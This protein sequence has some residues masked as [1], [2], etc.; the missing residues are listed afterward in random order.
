MTQTIVITSG[1]G[2]VGKTNICV[3]AA[4]ELVRRNYRTC[5]FDADLGLANVNILLG[6]EPVS[7]LD[8]YLFGDKTLN[9]II[10]QTKFG[11]DVI[12]GSSGIEKIAN[13][14]L[15]QISALVSSFSHIKGYDYFLIDTSSGI[16]RGVIAFCL[17]S[18]ET[19][20]VITSEA[21]SLTD[22]YALLKVM[23]L[24]NYSGTVKILVNKSPSIPQAKETY[25]RFKE[26]AN[27][28]LKL[29]IAPVGIILNDP[30][31]DNSIAHQE[32][33]LV[34]YPDTIAAHC[35]KA[36]VSNLVTNESTGDDFSEFWQ[37]YFEFSLLNISQPKRPVYKIAKKKSFKLLSPQD[38]NFQ[39]D[40]ELPA[41]PGRDQ[42]LEVGTGRSPHI[43]HEPIIPFAHNGGIF[44]ASKLAG[45]TSLLSKALELQTKGELTQEILLLLFTSDPVLMIKALQMIY[46]AD[47]DI[48]LKKRV[49]TKQQLVED[50]GP[51]ALTKLLSTTTTQKAFSYPGPANTSA[52]ATA[53]WAHSY[54]TALLAESIAELNG[55]P[56]PEEAFIAGLIHDIGK[57]AL[58]TDYPEMY[59]QFSEN[60]D[61]SEKLLEMEQHIFA[62]THAEVAARA[63]R[64]WQCDGFLV[65]A[66]Q[67]HTAPF[68]KIET[69]FSL[70]KI[71]F[72]ASQTAKGSGETS[73]TGEAL[74]GLS[75]EK[76]QS[77]LEDAK[78][79]TEQL[80]DWYGISLG[81][82]EM[83]KSKGTQEIETHFRHQA[84]E[85][86]ILQNVLPNTAPEKELSEITH[87][88][89]QA[90]DILFQIKPALCLVPDG[91]HSVLKATGS[92]D[93]FGWGILTDCEFS[94]QWQ[95]SLVVKSFL[96]GEL[97]IAIEGESSG[98]LP[99]ADRQLLHSLGTQGFVCV[100]MVSKTINRGVLVFG[101]HKTQLEKIHS[102]KNRLEQFGA[103]VAGI[104]CNLEKN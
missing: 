48:V 61:D 23:A 52:L 9:E 104:I 99:L 10:I 67:Y 31:I 14:D 96:S 54:T 4:I 53:F 72:L 62:T 41:M 73:S 19:I 93:Y 89:F 88:V 43:S 11:I 81:W 65:S 64:A 90:F 45:P 63:L 78:E 37:R 21:T 70:I 68:S 76:M 79:K 85:Y 7:T 100:P 82:K 16:A 39:P 8:D 102:L 95:K 49:T 6:I 69:A 57:L 1:K 98:V 60:F 25:S 50:L 97:K 18:T 28:H 94:L 20:I 77:L 75:P 66:V 87:N 83:D 40:I 71:V 29:K 34:L 56:Y 30:N 51:G 59:V 86:S 33:A 32:P 3:N 84:M 55:Y 92:P 74:F 36:M 80:A 26:V 24:N 35:I 22:A 58:L 42:N 2:G 15:E 44:D 103:Q 13:L 12:A 38:I 91:N 46:G 17:A 101:I 27:R 47:A 5:L